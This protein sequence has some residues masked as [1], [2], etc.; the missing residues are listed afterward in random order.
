MTNIEASMQLRECGLAWG[1][2]IRLL[3]NIT[4]AE[5]V[6]VCDE[7]HQLRTIVDL[8]RQVSHLR[9]QGEESPKLSDELAN[10]IDLLD[11]EDV[12]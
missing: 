12:E 2:G 9:D 4:A 6:S 11:G 8:A 7:L 10:A 3:G 5:I 1:P